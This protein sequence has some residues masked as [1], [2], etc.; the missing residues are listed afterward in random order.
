MPQIFKLAIL[1]MNNDFVEIRA[2]EKIEAEF[3]DTVVEEVGKR[4]VG[5]MKTQAQVKE[6]LREEL[7]KFLSALK[8][9]TRKVL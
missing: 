3:V 5:L 7:T 9:Q 6:I 8:F 1:D 2:E 4:D